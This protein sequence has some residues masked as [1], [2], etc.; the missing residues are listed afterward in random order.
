MYSIKSRTRKIIKDFIEKAGS[1]YKIDKAYIFG[2]FAKDRW[3]ENSDVDIAI[4][5]KNF[6]DNNRIEVLSNLLL[7]VSQYKIDI[8]PLVFS[9]NDLFDKENDFVKNEIKK[10]GIE[11]K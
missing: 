7:M 5:S 11:I 2:S 8:Q 10:R 3:N 9:Y 1:E 4:F 6:N